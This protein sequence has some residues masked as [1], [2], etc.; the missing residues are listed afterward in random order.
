MADISIVNYNSESVTDKNKIPEVFND[1]F[2]G[3][4]EKLA[5][6]IYPSTCS[7]SDYILKVNTNGSRF[8]FKLLKPVDV[9]K[10][11]S[12]LKNGK[13]TG[14]H[15][16]PNRIL[17]NVKD[18]LTPSITDI[19]NASIKSKTFPDDFKIARL[20]PIFKG[21]DTES[22][23]NYR[24]I[25]ILAS[26]ARIFERLLY[27]QL[28]DFLATNKI[29]NDKQ[30]G[31]RSL[32]STALALIDCSTNWLLNI[33][34]GVTNLTVFLNIKKAFDTIDHSILLEKLRY[35]GIM[36]G[37]LDFF[38]SYLRN[39]KQCCNVNGQLSSVK[40]IKY[41]VPQ[42]SILGPLL[43]ILYMNDLPCYVE[44]GYI[45]MYSDDTSLS[46]SVKTCEDIN[47]KVIPNT[48]QISDWL[49]ANKLSLNVI[50]TEF[51]LLGSSQRI[52]KFG[53]LI[54]IRVD[55][56]LIRRTS[57]VKYLG[58]IID[59]T[60]SWDMQIDSI[61]KKVRKNIG[62]IKHVRDSVPKE[63]LTLLYK[64]LVEL[65]FRYCSSTWGKCGTSLIDKLQTLQNRAARAVSKVKFDETDHEQFLKSLGWLNIRQLT[66]FDTAS[67]MFKISR[68]KMPK[69]TQELFTKCETIHQYNTRS[70][71]SGNLTLSGP[72]G[73][74][75]P[76]WPNSQL[77]IRNLLSY[78]A[79]T[80]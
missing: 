61:S 47:E 36:G 72:G 43:F 8:E 14:M 19:F 59:E 24:P 30:W 11:F 58:V 9:Y 28:D 51:M 60:L 3:V 34:K 64:T 7:S 80:W 38:R 25:S 10:V 41:G 68:Q 65:Y 79:Q 71:N 12:K 5:K 23:G 29:L 49:K 62:V 21:G 67:L 35:Y 63:S 78:E 73:A 27:K 4:G 53:S 52:L 22:L 56:N 32:H 37:E 26:I 57:F 74:Q 77:P 66:D 15:L 20:T 45:T 1:H 48:L 70:V 18:I 54:A 42:G 50:K 16:I 44:N 46:N 13:A 31:F 76:G 2:V 33:D 69:Q 75:R 39:R 40:N 6:D 55:N 17:K